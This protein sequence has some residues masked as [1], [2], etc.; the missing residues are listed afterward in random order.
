MSCPS[1]TNLT[2][3]DLTQIYYHESGHTVLP[4]APYE[5]TDRTVHGLLHP[6][7]LSSAISSFSQGAT[8][9]NGTTSPNGVKG[10]KGTNSAKKSPIPI[11]DMI[12]EF[13]FY[14]SRYTYAIQKVVESLRKETS[15]DALKTPP[16]RSAFYLKHAQHLHQKL[17]DFIQTYQGIRQA[18]EDASQP[19]DPAMVTFSNDLQSQQ[20][21]LEAQQK[22]IR[23]NQAPAALYKQMV[24]YSEEKTRRSDNLLHLYTFLNVVALGLLVYVYKAAE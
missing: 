9:A 11:D 14:H 7:A 8:G 13:C 6:S 19:V 2:D 10:A 1:V 21:K 16:P 4:S 23:S 15:P 3:S 17:M 22:V 12:A 24:L 5:T 18:L 20:G